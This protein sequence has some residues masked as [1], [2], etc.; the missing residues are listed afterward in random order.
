[1]DCI[2]IFAL[3]ISGIESLRYKTEWLSDPTNTLAPRLIL[4]TMTFSGGNGRP[5]G[6]L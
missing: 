4:S 2:S 3:L 5:I 1:M 6:Y